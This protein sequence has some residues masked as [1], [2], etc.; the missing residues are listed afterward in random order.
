MAILNSN[1]KMSLTDEQTKLGSTAEDAATE[2]PAQ[3]TRC[4]KKTAANQG[5]VE[6]RQFG[7]HPTRGNQC[8]A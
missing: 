6:A 7:Q 5:K 4:R 2:Q 3:A 8:E 1:N